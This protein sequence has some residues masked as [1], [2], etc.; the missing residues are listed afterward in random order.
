MA[1]IQSI[2]KIAIT[3]LYLLNLIRSRGD[4]IIPSQGKT[5]EEV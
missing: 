2:L 1:A 3:V 5:P 4:F